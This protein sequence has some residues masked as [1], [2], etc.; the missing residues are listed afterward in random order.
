VDDLGA[1]ARFA[2]VFP[3]AIALELNM[4]RSD[5]HD[6]AVGSLSRAATGPSSG[7]AGLFRRQC[8]ILDLEGCATV[9]QHTADLEDV[10]RA[11][12]SGSMPTKTRCRI[13]RAATDALGILT[14]S[15]VITAM[16]A[17]GLFRPARFLPRPLQWRHLWSVLD[18]QGPLRRYRRANPHPRSRERRIGRVVPSRESREVLH[19]FQ[20][21]H[22]CREHAVVRGRQKYPNAAI[23]FCA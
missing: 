7:V 11:T 3:G 12:A 17:T 1:A 18:A 6:C 13:W 22:W 2:A 10:V 5:R 23:A 4:R 20:Y 8:G 9:C 19:Y 16:M 15:L 21:Q 14:L